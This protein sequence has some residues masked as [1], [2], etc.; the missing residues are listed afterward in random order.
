MDLA[1]DNLQRLICHNTQAYKQTNKPSKINHKNKMLFTKFLHYNKL[2]SPVATIE[3]SV[4]T[5][6]W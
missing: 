3:I 4:N 6:N 5:F 2:N 1:L